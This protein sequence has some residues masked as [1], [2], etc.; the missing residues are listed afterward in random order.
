MNARHRHFELELGLARLNH[1]RD[2]GRALRI[3]RGRER[4]VTFA[5]EQPGSRIQSHP[6]C[7][8]QIHLAPGV[9]IREVALRAARPIEGFLIWLELDQITGHKASCESYMPRQLAQQP[10]GI[11][12]RPAHFL[13]CLFWCLDARLQA[14]KITDVL[15]EFLV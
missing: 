15:P 4:D 13:Q 10:R 3:G 1:S 9:Q 7:A 14:D 12:T 6:A 2:R 5:G 8:R 11:A